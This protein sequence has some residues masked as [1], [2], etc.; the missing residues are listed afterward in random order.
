MVRGKRSALARLQDRDE[1]S[2]FLCVS[3]SRGGGAGRM[4]SAPPNVR[5]TSPSVGSE[6]TL[7]PYEENLLRQYMHNS[8]RLQQLGIPSLSSMM[9]NMRASAPNKRKRSCKNSKHSD[10]EYEPSQDDT[11]E[12]D[13]IDD[14]NDRGSKEKSCKKTKQHTSDMHLAGVKFRSR[15]RLY[16]EQPPTRATR[17]LK[18]IAQADASLTPSN[19]SVPSPSQPNVTQAGELVGNYD[20]HTQNAKE[21]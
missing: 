13:S 12:R 20:G 10:T 5:G 15:K 3:P 7:L 16:V 11:G 19:I 18:S 21:G 17:R 9:P 2:Q 4:R 6:P 1:W 8:A 14:D